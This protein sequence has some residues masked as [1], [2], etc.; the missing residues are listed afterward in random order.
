MNEHSIVSCLAVTSLLLI[1]CYN[2]SVTFNLKVLKG[3]DYI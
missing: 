2:I 3:T 1:Q